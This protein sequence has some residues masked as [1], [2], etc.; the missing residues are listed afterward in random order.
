MK[1]LIRKDTKISYYMWDNDVEVTMDSENTYISSPNLIPPKQSIEGY[2]ERNKINRKKMS[3]NKKGEG[4][5]SKT[6]IILKQSYKNSS[7]I[8]CTLY[9]GRTHQIRLHLT[10]I[11]N[12]IVGDNIYGKNKISKFG[13][14]K[15]TFNKFLILK[16]F[17]RQALHAT[18]LGFFHPTHKK[19]I[20]FSSNLPS[21]M[22]NL[23]DLLLKY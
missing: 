17:S 13:L 20:E 15:N 8:E 14:E 12:P 1:I 6:D 7:L 11:Q 10:S 4:K 5:Y 19:N 16:N 3:L 21:D 22:K 23:I 9:T 2:I 18:H